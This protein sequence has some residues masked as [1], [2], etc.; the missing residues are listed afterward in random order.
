M[1]N[2]SAEQRQREI[3]QRESFKESAEK[4]KTERKLEDVRNLGVA[5]RLMRRVQAKRFQI[6]FEDEEGE[7]P[8]ETRL[9]T[10]NERY[11]ALKLN[12]VLS[13]AGENLDQY[14][15]AMAGLKDLAREV[16]VTPGMD[17]YYDSD[18]VSDD[19]ILAVVMRTVY[20]TLEAVGDSLTSF[21][22][23]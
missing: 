7:F 12:E 16:T 14:Q 13:K 11:Q 21:R 6:V 22:R 3:E 10:S 17:A 9:M 1:S 23:E 2:V 18:Q 4:R 15:E 20:G 19:V 5:E 8:V